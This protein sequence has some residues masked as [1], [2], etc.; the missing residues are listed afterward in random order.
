MAAQGD[1]TK[2]AT[3]KLNARRGYGRPM[4]AQGD[5]TKTATAK[6]NARRGYGRPMAAQSDKTKTATAKL[7]ARRGYGRPVAAQSDK[8]VA[9]AGFDTAARLGGLAGAGC[10]PLRFE[11]SRFTRDGRLHLEKDVSDAPRV[12]E[13]LKELGE[14]FHTVF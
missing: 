2:T 1:K 6:L 13:T 9:G 4:A 3:A 8:T 7:N 14:A 12:V 5:K 11:A 10:L